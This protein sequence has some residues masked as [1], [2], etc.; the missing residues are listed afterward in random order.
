MIEKRKKKLTPAQKL[1]VYAKLLNVPD[2]SAEPEGSLSKR[3][4]LD[5][6]VVGGLLTQM[7]GNPKVRADLKK[8][9]YTD[10]Q[11]PDWVTASEVKSADAAAGAVAAVAATGADGAQLQKP[12]PAGAPV[13]VVRARKKTSAEQSTASIAQL[14]KQSTPTPEETLQDTCAPGWVAAEVE[15]PAESKGW[16]MVRCRSRSPLGL[17]YV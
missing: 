16:V 12:K 3:L 4:N 8:I 13:Q 1:D 11:I 10:E 2:P 5:P 17:P 7:R 6:K 15:S 14:T 9:G